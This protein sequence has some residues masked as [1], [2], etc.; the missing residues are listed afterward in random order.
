METIIFV[1]I[2]LLISQPKNKIASDHE[3]QSH[4]KNSICA[5]SFFNVTAVTDVP[6]AGFRKQFR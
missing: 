4:R 3:R 2:V 5:T 1:K 6:L